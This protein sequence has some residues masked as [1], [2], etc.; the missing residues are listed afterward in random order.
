MGAVY[1][2][3]DDIREIMGL[4]ARGGAYEDDE[5]NSGSRS[6]GRGNDR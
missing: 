2:G 4:G 6:R 1:G 5:E 3:L